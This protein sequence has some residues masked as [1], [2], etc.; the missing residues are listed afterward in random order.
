MHRRAT[1]TK[2]ADNTVGPVRWE[3]RARR[4][5]P[6]WRS[7]SWATKSKSLLFTA[8]VLDVAV[9]VALRSVYSVEWFVDW[10]FPIR[11]MAPLSW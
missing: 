11:V 4:A 1:H 6:W 7:R 2:N 3:V 10:L 8:W 5:C 9:G